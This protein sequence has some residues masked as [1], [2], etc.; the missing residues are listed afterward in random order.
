MT[1]RAT[2]GGGVVLASGGVALILASAFAP[3]SLTGTAYPQI[4]RVGGVLLGVGASLIVASG[5]ERR[6][7]GRALLVTAL[8]GVV[9]VC[10][11]GVLLDS[12]LGGPD[13]GFAIRNPSDVPWLGWEL[14]TLYVFA[15]A[16]VCAG[17]AVA[18]TSSIGCALV[19]A[20]RRL[21]A[22]RLTA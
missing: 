13:P 2:R 21:T 17:S 10:A 7:R 5:V 4:A 14:V 1:A 11:A 9:V 6:A 20:A 8:C 18:V 19:V 16:A 12:N 15:P 3:P 22:G